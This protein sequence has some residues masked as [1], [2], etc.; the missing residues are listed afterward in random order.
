[1]SKYNGKYR[2]NDLVCLLPVDLYQFVWYRLK[3]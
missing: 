1:M 3:L 2:Y